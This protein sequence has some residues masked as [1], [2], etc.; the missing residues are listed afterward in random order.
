MGAA[1]AASTPNLAGAADMAAADLAGADLEPD[2]GSFPSFMT[3]PSLAELR[4]LD[5][6]DDGM[7]RA[8]RDCGDHDM[9]ALR[10]EVAAL[11]QLVAE[12]QQ[13]VLDEVEA[14]RY[15]IHQVSHGVGG[16]TPHGCC[17][18]AVLLWP[19]AP[20]PLSAC[21]TASTP[22]QRRSPDCAPANIAAFCAYALPAGTW[23]HHEPPRDGAG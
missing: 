4:R 14:Q 23:P 8:S 18:C 21:R 7:G 20:P 6:E 13:S 1:A 3:S 11:K 22:K 5:G 12:Q 16:W 15:L 2:F 10:E 19:P 17:A 9:E